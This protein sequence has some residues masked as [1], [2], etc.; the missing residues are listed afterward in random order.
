MIWHAWTNMEEWRLH[1]LAQLLNLV[2]AAANVAVRHIR[3]LLHLA[4]NQHI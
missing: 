2:L 4:R 3:L 1:D